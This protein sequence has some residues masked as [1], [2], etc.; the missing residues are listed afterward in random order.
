[1]AQSVTTPVGIAAG[2]PKVATTSIAIPYHTG[3]TA[4]V[5]YDTLSGN[6]PKT[7][8]NFCAIWQGSMIPWGQDPKPPATTI[9]GNSPDGTVV[10]EDLEITSLE[11]IIGYGVGPRQEDIC[12]SAVIAA[13]RLMGPPSSVTMRLNHIGSNSLS[14]HFQTLAGYRPQAAGNWIGLWRGF[15][16]PYSAGKPEARACV[17]TDSS[18]GDLGLN[19]VPMIRDTDYTLVYFMDASTTTAAVILNFSTTDPNGGA[20]P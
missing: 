14:V 1:M 10:L 9:P 19:N 2:T 17:K 13:Q 6:Q 11:Y 18:E 5:S 3:T 7:N 12:A 15:A 8:C 4:S 20:S 16:S